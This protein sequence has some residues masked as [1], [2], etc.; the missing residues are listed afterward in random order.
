MNKF[1][2]ATIH[3]ASAR[4]FENTRESVREILK[5]KLRRNNSYEQHQSVADNTDIVAVESVGNGTA[6]SGVAESG[7]A[8]S[9]VAK[10]GVARKSLERVSKQIH[11]EHA[12]ADQASDTRTH[13]L[14]THALHAHEHRHHALDARCLN[15][16]MSGRRILDDVSLYVDAGEFVALIG[17][18]GA[19]KT[20][21]IRSILGLIEHSDAGISSGGVRLNPRTVGYVPQRHEF[22]WDFPITVRETVVSGLTGVLGFG[23]RPKLEHQKA[24]E[25]A[26][27]RADVA[28]LANRP[29]GELSG[30]QR[31]RV[32][33]ARALVLKPSILLLDEPFTGLDMPTQE[34]LN[35]L[36][37]TLAQE[38]HA[39]LMTTHDLISALD[40]CD[41]L[42][43][44][45]Q[46]VQASGTRD[47][48]VD[49]QVWINTFRIRETNP[50][51]AA[52]GVRTRA[53]ESDRGENNNELYEQNEQ[54]KYH[55]ENYNE[56]E[57]HH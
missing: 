55:S 19:G 45:N 22:A 51:L 5:E 8:E 37:R 11:S 14:R 53:H 13:A 1:N 46:T 54:H 30:G 18:N 9:G 15:V 36:F 4:F 25:E 23:R 28:H 47:D 32:L 16:Q 7:V 26:M 41:R 27:K 52:L 40:Q 38:G 50:L 17:P 35:D 24:V 57:G 43:L 10:S 48:L 39:V 34:M 2:L 33:V 12:Y 3:H 42:Y 20:T 6:E 44:I 21:L 29:I 56:Q 49:A 31:Q